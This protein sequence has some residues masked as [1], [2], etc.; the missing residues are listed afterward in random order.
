M[1]TKVGFKCKQFLKKSFNIQ[2][3]SSSSVVSSSFSLYSDVN[4][5]DGYYSLKMLFSLTN[6]TQ[7]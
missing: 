3:K 1:K 5:T 7:I 2:E 6:Y 4:Y